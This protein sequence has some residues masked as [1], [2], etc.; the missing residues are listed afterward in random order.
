MVLVWGI[1]LSVRPSE[2]T[3]QV[4]R[5]TSSRTRIVKWWTVCMKGRLEL[6]ERVS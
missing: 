5:E 4:P 2:F 3:G 6:E 1:K